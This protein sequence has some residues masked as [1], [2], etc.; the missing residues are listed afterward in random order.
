MINPQFIIDT[1]REQDYRYYQILDTN[2]HVVTAQWQPIS[3]EE[4]IKRFK[5]FLKNAS[6]AIYR[7]QIFNTN[8]K[9]NNG[10]PKGQPYVYEIMMSES[11]K[12][13]E[14]T[15]PVSSNPVPNQQTPMLGMQEPMQ[16]VFTNGGMMGGVGLDKYLGEKDRVLELLLRIQ[17][18]EMDKRYLEEKLVRREEEL[19]KE[20]ESQMSSEQRI[21]GII[22]QVLPTFMAGFQGQAPM[23]GTQSQPMENNKTVSTEKQMVISSVNKLMEIDPNF[24]KNITALAKLA[25]TKP[26]VYAMAVNYLNNL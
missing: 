26:E 12:D 25:E 23:N 9:K 8:E 5:S 6:A 16:Q 4:S 7:V 18:L 14:P 3:V 24:S 15:A 19:R 20:M 2:Y 13:D 1:M 22:N 17:Q 10:D 11:L 21:N